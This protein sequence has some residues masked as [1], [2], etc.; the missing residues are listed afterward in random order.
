MKGRAI[1][2]SPSPQLERRK[3]DQRQY[4][5]DDPE[6]NDDGWL[7][8]AL[9]LVVVM[10]RR[11]AEDALSGQLVGKDLDDDGDRLEHEEA[12]NDPKDDLVLG[13]HRHAAKRASAG[14]GARVP[15]E[16]HRWRGV[17]PEETESCTDQ[18]AT[19]DR[20]FSRALDVVDLQ[21]VRIDHIA[22]QIGDEGKA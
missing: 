5:G 13:D 15:H 17:V 6:T 21:V 4:D 2:L 7:L 19:E 1:I 11:H 14:E 3:P 8:P 22:D 20:Q 18:R 12:A 16:D 9:L 10:Q